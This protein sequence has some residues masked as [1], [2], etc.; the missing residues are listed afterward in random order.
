MSILAKYQDKNVEKFTRLTRPGGGVSQARTVLSPAAGEHRITRT[1]SGLENARR[2]H[3]ERQG[4]EHP[5]G[6]NTRV[7][8]TQ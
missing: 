4:H 5:S 3:R 1:P 2:V 6:A 8:H 7:R